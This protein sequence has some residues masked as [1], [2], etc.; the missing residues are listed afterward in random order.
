MLANAL[1]GAHMPAGKC[2]A[3]RQAAVETEGDK[4]RLSNSIEVRKTPVTH[5][6]MSLVQR[7][8]QNFSSRTAAGA[9]LKPR[10]G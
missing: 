2:P 9:G 3:G 10:A 4:Q 7:E 8:K 5:L 1:S 6:H